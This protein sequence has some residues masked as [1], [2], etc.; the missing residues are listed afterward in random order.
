[1]R[2]IKMEIDCRGKACPQPVI[3]AKQALDQLKEGEIVLV[4]DN[5]GSSENVERFARSQGCSVQVVKKEGDYYL[6]LGKPRS[7]EATAFL[8]EGQ[9][10][11][12]TVAYISSQFLGVG[13]DA[14][15][16]ILMRAFLKTLLEM[17]NKPD[18]LI[19]INS[20]V[21]LT[22]EGSEV[23]ESLRAL[24]GGGV[25]ILSCGTCLDFYGLKEKLRVG[26]VSNMYDI[27]RSLLEA[28]TI[29]RP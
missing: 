1:M 8:Q 28:D 16:A 17:E 15:G 13:D 12:K 19:F 6:R 24:A 3:T 14:L 2:R 23:L 26:I 25:G 5:P 11:R 27:A 7:G 18:P 21:K 9:K 10:A 29:I 22:S 20:G 4:V